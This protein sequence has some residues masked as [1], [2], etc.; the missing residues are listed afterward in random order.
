MERI[1]K[2]K[3]RA[4]L[5]DT[6]SF[7]MA[8]NESLVI[9]CDFTDEI[10]RGRFRLVVRHGEKKQTFSLAKTDSVVISPEWMKQSL[11]NLDFSLVLLNETE[12][13]VI[14]DDYQIEPLK[15]ET[16]DGNFTFTAMVQ[17]IIQRQDEQ[18]RRMAALEERLSAYDETG[19]PLTA[20]T[21]NE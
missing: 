21:E 5:F 10:R 12:S 9:K 3:G 14:K 8:E 6:P 4:G 13:A 20:E 19:V 18:E 2:I 1:L 17:E 16:V 7:L 15:L 11:E